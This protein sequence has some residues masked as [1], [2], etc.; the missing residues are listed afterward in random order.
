MLQSPFAKQSFEPR[1]V[2]EHSNKEALVYGVALWLLS[3]P[4]E[5]AAPTTGVR[6]VTVTATEL[7]CHYPTRRDDKLDGGQ[8]LAKALSEE[9]LCDYI[10]SW[11]QSI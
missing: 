1:F 5:F 4:L 6:R 11:L 2:V 10:W 7:Y 3:A 8:A 9:E